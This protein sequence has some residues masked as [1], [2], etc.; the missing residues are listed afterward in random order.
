MFPE[1]KETTNVG[2]LHC[3]RPHQD[4]NDVVKRLCPALCGTDEPPESPVLSLGRMK[5]KAQQ[6]E[7]EVSIQK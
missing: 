6:K 2:Y 1:K 4:D 7:Q 3:R 5:I